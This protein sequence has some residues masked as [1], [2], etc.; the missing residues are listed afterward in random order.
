[1]EN[2]RGYKS[3]HFSKL[4]PNHGK[5]NLISISI[6]VILLGVNTVKLRLVVSWPMSRGEFTKAA[7]GCFFS[8]PIKGNT[9]HS[10]TTF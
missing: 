10:P 8:L 2:R 1:M 9:F 6:S 4:A 5:E 3:V 7:S